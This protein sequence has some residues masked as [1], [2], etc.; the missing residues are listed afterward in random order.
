MQLEQETGQCSSLYLTPRTKWNTINNRTPTP[1]T[2][3]ALYPSPHKQ[4]HNY[5]PIPAGWKD[6]RQS[7]GGVNI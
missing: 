7:I 2:L 6:I 5:H 4:T 1:L 3:T